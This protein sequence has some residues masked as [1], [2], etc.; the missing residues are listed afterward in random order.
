MKEIYLVA[1][2]KL[3]PGMPDDFLR[4]GKP[5]VAKKKKIRLFLTLREE[6]LVRQ[7]NQSFLC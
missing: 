3:N 6:A 7:Q 1:S 4:T 2:G 5:K